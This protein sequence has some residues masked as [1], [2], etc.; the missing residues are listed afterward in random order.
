M[1]LEYLSPYSLDFD[2]VEEGFSAMKAWIQQ[3]RDYVQGELLGKAMCDLYEMLWEAV[4]TSMTVEKAVG[5][6]GHSGYL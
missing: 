3:N 6:F 2:P 4:F 1:H 5:W